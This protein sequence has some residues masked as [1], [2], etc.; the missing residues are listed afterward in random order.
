MEH[1]SKIS[2]GVSFGIL[3]KYFVEIIFRG[4]LKNFFRSSVGFHLGIYPQ[5]FMRIP[6]RIRSR[7]SS[8]HYFA[9][10][11]KKITDTLENFDQRFLAIYKMVYPS[12]PWRI[13]TGV[14]SETSRFFLRVLA[15]I[16]RNILWNSS[17]YLFGNSD[18]HFFF[19]ESIC[20]I[21]GRFLRD[22]YGNFSTLH[23]MEFL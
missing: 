8:R 11:F 22:S 18:S 14:L 16:F 10:D 17:N 7:I 3:I 9:N 15:H 2:S 4:F 12:F 6:L 21:I 20:K 19:R 5:S 13:A 23:L 1:S